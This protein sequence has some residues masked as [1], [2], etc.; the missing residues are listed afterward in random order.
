VK[1]ST[2]EISKY[3]IIIAS[4][5]ACC[6]HTLFAPPPPMPLTL[7]ASASTYALF[8]EAKAGAEQSRAEQGPD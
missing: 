8:S 3:G 6:H 5:Q 4:K 7:F 2:D 1:R